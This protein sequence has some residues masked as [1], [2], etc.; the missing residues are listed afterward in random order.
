V[1][2]LMARRRLNGAS[3]P[4]RDQAAPAFC[5]VPPRT[6]LFIVD[7]SSELSSG[8]GLRAASMPAIG[9]GLSVAPFAQRQRNPRLHSGVLGLAS[10]ASRWAGDTLTLSQHGDNLALI[11]GLSAG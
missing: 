6:S 8:V 2:V 1:A 10:L 7:C 5:L 4:N 3:L 11:R 9:D